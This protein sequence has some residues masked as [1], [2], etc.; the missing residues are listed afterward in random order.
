MADPVDYK[1]LYLKAVEDRKQAEEREK[2]AEERERR[3]E[4]GRKQAEEEAR[5]ET[6]RNRKTTFEELIQHCHNLLSCPLR[7]QEPKKSTTGKIPSPVGKHCP[8]QLLPWTDCS[9]KQRE[10]Y[11]SVC[12]YL[13][14]V[15]R[16]AP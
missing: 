11:S 16:D 12:R 14:P 6:E 10:I 1:A 15:G 9:T 2:Q 4:D 7:A 5:R 8:L 3:A 13:Q